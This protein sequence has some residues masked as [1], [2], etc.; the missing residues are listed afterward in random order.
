MERGRRG[1]VSF[2]VRSPVIL[3]HGELVFSVLIVWNVVVFELF[4]NVLCVVL[5]RWCWPIVGE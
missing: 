2:G 4:G 3:A 5:C 1:W